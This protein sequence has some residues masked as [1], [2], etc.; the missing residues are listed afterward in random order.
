M[1]AEYR[2]RNDFVGNSFM[3]TL[4]FNMYMLD[5]NNSIRKWF[6]T[7]FENQ[8]ISSSLRKYRKEKWHKR[9]NKMNS[10]KDN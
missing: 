1:Y 7:F 3:Q 9:W 4:V 2:A 6:A 5:K 10:S 8:T